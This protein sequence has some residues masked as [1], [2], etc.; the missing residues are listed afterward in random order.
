MLSYRELRESVFEANIELPR[1]GLVLYTFGNVS[2]IDRASGMIA[3]KPSGVEYDELTP[4]MMVLVDLD[5]NVADSRYRPSSDTKTHIVLYREFP[6]IGGVTHTHSSYATAWAQSHRGIPCFGTTHA[7]Y[8]YGEVPCTAMLTDESIAGDY[9][10]ET[11]LQIVKRFR[12][13][14]PAQVP[15]VL[16][17]GH[18]PFTW[19]KSAAD[20]VYHAAILEELAKTA[21]VTLALNPAAQPIPQALLDRHFLRKHGAQAYYGQEG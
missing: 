1:R 11:G 4:E 3:I 14:D 19:G 16:V 8:C 7:D 21:S 10:T 12:G 15:M 18:G 20:S 13:I 5:G 17:A 6:F 9:E 2:G